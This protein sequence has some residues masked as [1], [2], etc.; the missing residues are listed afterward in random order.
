MPASWR[1]CLNEPRAPGLGHHVDGVELVHLL[2]VADHRV[3]D[4][5]GRLV[6]EVGH[7][8]VALLVGDQPLLV[9]LLRVDDALLVGLEDLLL[10]RRD[11]HV[12]LGHGDAGLGRVVEAEVLE[13]V[14]HLSDGGSAERLD[15]VVDEL[16]GV[17]LF[18][19]LVDEVV[20]RAVEA[21]RA[22][23]PRAPARCGR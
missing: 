1:I 7:L 10:L 16:D 6:P 13:G 8:D 15:Q 3:G 17:A 9:L 4:L 21:V 22:G 5:V 11:H 2:D 14:E 18:E 20:G 23:P 19:R 12:V